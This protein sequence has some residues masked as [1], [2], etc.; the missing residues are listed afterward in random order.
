MRPQQR[1]FFR[2]KWP[3]LNARREE[4]ALE[5]MLRLS[6]EPGGCSGCSYKLEM[7]DRSDVDEDEDTCVKTLDAEDVPPA[8]ARGPCVLRGAASSRRRAPRW[9]WTRGRLRW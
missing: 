5:R 7:T 9:S 2:A 1:V 8:H 3:D 4:G 6:V